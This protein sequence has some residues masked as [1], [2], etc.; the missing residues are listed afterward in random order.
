M[1]A[2]RRRRPAA[3][4]SAL[5]LAAALGVMATGTAHAATP[6]P[7]PVKRPVPVTRTV[8]Y[9]GYKFQVP[10]SWQVVNLAAH[11]TTCVRFDQHALYLGTPGANQDCPATLVGH[12]E[13]LLVQ[14]EA[15]TAAARGT[16]DQAVD[17]QYLAVGARVEVTGTY[18]KDKQLVRSILAKAGLPTNAPRQPKPA[19][20]T[21]SHARSLVTSMAVG[22][23][24]ANYTGQGFDACAAPSASTMSTWMS[25]SPY[26]AVGIYIG[27]GDRACTQPNLTASWVTQQAAAGWHF[28]P[29]YVGLQA[30]EISSPTTDGTAAAD[31]AVAQAQ[32]LGFGAG[33]P[34]YYDIEAYSSGYQSN[35]LGFLDAWTRELHAKGYNSG[36]YSSASTGISDLVNSIGT[37]FTEPDVIFDANWNG[38]AS[39]ADS[40]YVPA[41]DW[42]LHQRVHQYAGNVN[43]T[44]GGDTIGIDQDYLDVSLKTGV[45]ASAANTFYHAVRSSAGTWT[46]FNALGGANGATTFEGSQESIA[47]M[48]DGSSQVLGIGKDGNVYHEVRNTNGTWTGF[49]AL[50]GADGA[51]YFHGSDAAITGLP[52]GSSQVVA[53]GND[54]NIWHRVRNANG[55]W[56]NFQTI[57]GLNGAASFPASKVAIAGMPDGSSQVLAYGADGNMYLDV[58]SAAGTWSGWSLIAGA[59]GA[60]DFEGS[61]LAIAA[62]PDGSSQLLAIGNDGDVWHEIRS[63]AGV[64]T[65]WGNLNGVGTAYMAA[66]SIGIT[67]MPDGTSQVVAVGNDGNAY[68]ETRNTNGT[69]TGFTALAGPNGAAKFAADQVGIAG[70]PDGSSQVLATTGS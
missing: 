55:T 16:V 27:G 26:N 44:Y 30:S 35:V 33:T 4:V 5:S 49:Q 40:S 63:A 8:S 61:D 57:P 23:G 46:A 3:A 22:A 56:T 64:F 7:T 15:T 14:P 20:S 12:T 68:T 17:Q 6:G 36:V 66:S 37:G 51:T 34:L 47:A 70:M 45:A 65:G 48:P 24:T 9:L 2:N 13:A 43:A 69:W 67:G 62:M 11:P 59:N 53:I 52:D 50:T 29:L 41:T 1:P 38:V 10:G 28:M 32:S 42:S 25:D 60:A 54:G 19:G 39:T 31:D 58:R 21:S 18:S